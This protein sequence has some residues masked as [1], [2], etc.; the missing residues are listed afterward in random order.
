MALPIVEQIAENVELT[1]RGIRLVNGYQHDVEVERHKRDGNR[2]R[3]K[4]LVIYQDD[5]PK[6]D[7]TPQDSITWMQPFMVLCWAVESENSTNSIDRRLNLLAADVEKIMLA[8]HNRGG[9]ALDTITRAR[10]YITDT[11]SAGEGILV[12]FDVQYRVER[13]DPYTRR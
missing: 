5:P 6:Q 12:H 11:E 13:T 10:H 7:D 3:D 2:I 9:L 1:L 4:L 8:D